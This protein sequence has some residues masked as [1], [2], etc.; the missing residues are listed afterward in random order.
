M[1]IKD[2]LGLDPGDVFKTEGEVVYTKKPKE[3]KS[4]K[5]T[6]YSQFILLKDSSCGDKESLPLAV[7]FNRPEDTLEK[8]MK[9]K[10]KGSIR[11]Y[12]GSNQY[13]GKIEEKYIDQTEKPQESPKSNGNGNRKPDNAYWEKREKEKNG[14][15][16]RAVAIKGAVELMA[17]KQIKKDEF[18]D[19]V[20]DLARYVIKGQ[21]PNDILQ[22]AE[23]VL[24]GD[25]IEEDM[26]EE[27]GNADWEFAEETVSKG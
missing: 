18:W 27:E 12:N 22:E 25:V 17:N 8:G 5:G 6:F 23:E 19:W 11:E 9:L 26:A 2:I 13:D 3:L 15:V 4:D 16:G 20:K 21:Y 7:T 1:K 10:I 24:G 14:S